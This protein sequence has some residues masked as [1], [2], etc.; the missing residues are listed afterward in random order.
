MHIL[1]PNQQIKGG[2]IAILCFDTIYPSTCLRCSGDDESFL[3]W[4]STLTLLEGGN[5]SPL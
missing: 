2:P 5:A 1:I 4:L 3:E